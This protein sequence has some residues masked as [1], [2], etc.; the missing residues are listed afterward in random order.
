MTVLLALASAAA[1]GTSVVLQHREAA[2]TPAADALHLRLLTRLARRPVWLA[3]IAASGTA[4][5]L[6]TAALRH[7][8]LVVVQPLLTS[9]LVFALAL[10]A[11][12]TRR[13]LTVREWVAV[14][15]VVAGVSTLI[16]AAGIHSDRDVAP[17][18]L[19]W[20]AASV[21][22]ALVVTAAAR[23]SRHSDSR[24]RAIALGTAAGVA[25][26]FVAVLTKAFASDLARGPAA[27]VHGWALWA[28]A[29]AAVPAVVLVQT[30]YQAGELRLS[31]PVIAVLEP[32]VAVVLGIAL[33][34]ER[35]PVDPPRLVTL[36]F[37]AL[38]TGTGLWSLAASPGLTLES[39][40]P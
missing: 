36:A 21:A 16:V 26:G 28:L 11:L 34:H 25:N 10:V 3:G 15:A 31:L 38:V 18:P 37:A 8:S 33:F 30:V 23:R 17:G 1:F 22:V 29:A 13:R 32:V 27:V 4:F 7:G 9:A 19:A 40:S 2:S 35:V 5:I 39:I 24:R 12:S 6:Q 20:A 14:L